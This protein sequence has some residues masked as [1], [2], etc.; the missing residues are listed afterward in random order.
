M[1]RGGSALACRVNRAA[2]LRLARCML[3]WAVQAAHLA[4]VWTAR[5][6]AD[7]AALGRRRLHRETRRE[8]QR[9]R[10]AKLHRCP[11]ICSVVHHESCLPR[12]GK[13]WKSLDL[14]TLGELDGV[15][16][17]WDARMV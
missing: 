4:I 7:F 3:A 10:G 8:P 17:G 12:P 11:L 16:S 9:R 5:F 15:P 13:P 2:C 1:H 14:S 6:A